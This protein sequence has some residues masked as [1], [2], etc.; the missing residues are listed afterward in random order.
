MLGESEPMGTVEYML[1]LLSAPGDYTRGLLGGRHG[2]RLSGRELLTEYGLTSPNDPDAWEGADFAG[3]G[4]DMLTDPLTYA[5][6]PLAGLAKAK[7]MGRFGG[8]AAEGLAD[9]AGAASHAMPHPQLGMMA[10]DVAGGVGVPSGFSLGAGLG[11]SDD[12]VRQ[13]LLQQISGQMSGAEDDALRALESGPPIRMEEMEL[14]FRPPAEGS[15]IISSGNERLDRALQA[16][17]E[18]G[19]RPKF[20]PQSN[21][22]LPPIPTEPPQ[23]AYPFVGTKGHEAIFGAEVP[24]MREIGLPRVAGGT[25]SFSPARA[26]RTNLIGPTPDDVAGLTPEAMAMQEF[27]IDPGM[28]RKMFDES[29]D[30]MGGV[31]RSPYQRNVVEEAMG[32]GGQMRTF[33]EK[34]ERD[35]LDQIL[36]ANMTGNNAI[37]EQIYNEQFVPNRQK[38]LGLPQIPPDFEYGMGVPNVIR[39][40]R[41]Q[42]PLGPL[43]LLAGLGLGGAAAYQ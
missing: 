13:G 16:A 12:A 8:A 34:E 15:E 32:G 31:Y 26:A 17:R 2:E 28:S 33:L 38:L 5:L 30:A 19:W 23:G 40:A 36:R 10:G 43:A 20:G 18:T 41:E 6:G 14:G 42:P 25:E 11:Q 35:L 4:V 37:G 9:A 39:F 27:G 29:I 22:Q 1:N 24:T 7:I 3:A 21:P